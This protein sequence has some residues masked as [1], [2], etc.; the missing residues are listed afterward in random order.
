MAKQKSEP[1]ARLPAPIEMELASL[2]MDCGL[3]LRAEID[4]DH[5]DR[6]ADAYA[7]GEPV[8]PIRVMHDSKTAWVWDGNHR[9]IARRQAGF[10]TISVIVEHGTYREAI[11][12]AAGA[13]HEHGLPRSNKDKRT[14]VAKLLE[15]KVWARRSDRWI[16]ETCRVSRP[17]VMDVRQDI[18]AA[19]Q[20]AELPPA[21]RDQVA[22][23]PP[24]KT[25]KEVLDSVGA[26]TAREGKD[27]KTYQASKPKSA[28][29][30]TVDLPD[31]LRRAVRNTQA[32]G[33]PKQM[34]R[35]ARLAKDDPD[36]AGVVARMLR[37]CEVETVEEALLE[38]D[39]PEPEPQEQAS[40]V[41][42]RLLEHTKTTWRVEC[43]HGASPALGAAVLTQVSDEWL[44]GGWF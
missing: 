37:D 9:L 16:A 35:L 4:H 19:R 38:S 8:P 2:R 36:L 3:Q 28:P 42:R 5:V 21:E 27:G 7:A 31:E 18:E 24:E 33:D 40:A 10:E 44:S 1:A 15:D 23:L 22:E 20:V 12:R 43:P 41:L 29:A 13:N 34:A 11:L 39:S 25:A 30:A 17:L 32:A 26:P 6:L 14:A